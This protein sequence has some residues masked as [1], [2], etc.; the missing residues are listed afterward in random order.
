[1]YKKNCISSF[2]FDVVLCCCSG[3]A[4]SLTKKGLHE[5]EAILVHADS[6]DCSLR[7]VLALG[8]VSD[9]QQFSGLIFQVVANVS[10]KKKIFP[11]VLA[12]GGRYDELVSLVDVR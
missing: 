1:M 3:L 12:L 11:E 4:G 9:A 8:L 10:R 6:L 7:P 2:W 5:L